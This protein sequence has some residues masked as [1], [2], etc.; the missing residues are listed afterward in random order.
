MTN[1]EFIVGLSYADRLRLAADSRHQ[2]LKSYF[3]SELE[4]LTSLMGPMSEGPE[5]PARLSHKKLT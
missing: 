1:S 5:W 3:D 4:S 2:A